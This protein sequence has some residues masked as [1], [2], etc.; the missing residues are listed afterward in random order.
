MAEQTGRTFSQK[1]LGAKAGKDVVP[2]EIVDVT[3]DLAMSHDNTAAISKKFYSIGVDKVFDPDMH[4]IVLDHCSPAA[5]EKFAT[6]HKEIREFVETQ[7]IE[8]FYDVATG[9]CHQVLPEQGYA[10][11]AMPTTARDK[12]PF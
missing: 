8:K 11:P 3:P 10:L 1:I 5:N 6:N 12:R 9:V 4:I 7:G 2:G